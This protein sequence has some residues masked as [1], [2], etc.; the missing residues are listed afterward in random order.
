MTDHSIL[1]NNAPDF[2]FKK[3]AGVVTE[4]L[5][6]VFVDFPNALASAY[7]AR[8]LYKNLSVLDEASL[9]A[10]GLKREEIGRFAIE[11]SGL[12]VIERD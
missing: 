7:R 8:N 11:N 12:L 1:G 4:V 3:E 6:T 2:P 10:I 9:A 5:R